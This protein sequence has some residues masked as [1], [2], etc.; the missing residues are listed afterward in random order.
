VQETP[1][2]AEVAQRFLEAATTGDLQGLLDVLAP[3]VV[4]TSDGGGIMKAA[5]R[6]IVGPDKVARFLS[7]VRPTGLDLGVR[8]AE[9]NGRPVVLLDVEGQLDSL[10]SWD[11]RD[12]RIGHI[13]FVRNPEKLRHLA[14]A[15][16]LTRR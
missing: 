15:V 3:D 4:L 9:A 2:G 7:G 12:G 14:E 8:W 5:L 13:Y 1:D 16:G 11:V 10:V 6:P